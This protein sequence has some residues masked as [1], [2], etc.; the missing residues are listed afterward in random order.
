LAISGYFLLP[1]FEDAM[2]MVEG[3]AAA[4]Y[5]REHRS[6]PPPHGITYSCEVEKPCLSL[7]TSKIFLWYFAPWGSG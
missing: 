3:E 4:K 7:L 2:L 1:S 5:H 6:A